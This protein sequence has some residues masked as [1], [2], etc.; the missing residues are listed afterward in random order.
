MAKTLRTSGDYTIQAGDGY[1][2]GSG[3]NTITLNSLNVSVSG[4]LTVGGTSTTVSTTNT[5][6]EDNII[7]LNSGLSQSL[8]DSGIIIERGSTGDNAAIVWDESEDTFKLGTTTATGADKSGGITVTAGA[9]EVA[10]FTATTGTFSG[11]VTSVGFTV[12]GNLTAGSITT[13]AISS[14]G[15]NA[16][17]SIQPSGTGD[18]LLSALRV[19][20]TTLDSSDSSKIT[21]AEAVDVTG[22]LVT[23]TS[24]NIAGDGATVTGILDEDAMGSDSATKL[25][26]QQS[27][28][29]YIDDKVTAE[30]LDFQGDSG[31]ALSIDL[32]SETLTIAGGTNITTTGSGNTITI[33]LDS[34]LSGFASVGVGSLTLAGNDI[35][36]SSNADINITPGG[37]GT[38]VI[39][40]LTIDSNIS[41]ADNII[42]ATASNSDLELSAS[43]SGTVNVTSG[44]ITAA[45]TTVGNWGVTGTQTITGQLDVDY[46]RIKDN[47]ISTNA[48]NANLIISGSSSGNVVIDDVDIGG[49]AIDN[50]VIGATTPL[51]GTFTALTSSGDVTIDSNININGNEIKTTAS[52]A[53]LELAG[54]GSGGVKISGFTFPTSDGSSGQFIKTDG[55]G[56]LSF[57]TAGATLNHSDI[58]DATTT[59]ASSATTVMNTF[60][61]ATYRSAKYFISITTADEARYEIL[62][63]NVTHNG[64]DAFISTFGSVSNYGGSGGLAT[65]TAAISGSNVEVRVTNITA[66][67]TVFKFQRIA[68]DV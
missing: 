52:N 58:A 8:N 21:L 53:N 59:V 51:A 47:V 13:N 4:N 2:A 23:D 32:D 34:T 17:I 25:A 31:G 42:K 65:F 39:G 38:I 60:P 55:L 22:A 67:S 19:N 10:A 35:T 1:N 56:T 61:H 33:A 7:E 30:D 57:A 6:I 43:G 48:S 40:D 45:V 29:K 66:D 26:T 11:A 9:L 50:T 24:L 16:D 3:A 63:A 15:S 44:L 54:N 46:V 5:T 41:I 49:G 28:K 68:L 18:V 12:G 37:T 62:E 27:I 14:N 64:S 20:G 36:S